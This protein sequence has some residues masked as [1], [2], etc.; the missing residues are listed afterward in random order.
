M[1][2]WHVFLVDPYFLGGIHPPLEE[3]QFLLVFFDILAN[4][5]IFPD[6]M[7]IIH[8]A[9]AP[10]C[11]TSCLL[12]WSDN[13]LY[14][15]GTSRDKRLQVLWENYRKWCESQTPPLGDRAQRKLFTASVLKPDS[16]K[17]VELSQKI[18]NATS[19]RY[20]VFWLQRVAMQF[21]NQSGTDEDMHLDFHSLLSFLN[22]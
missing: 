15:V 3:M 22:L 4:Q 5:G 7:H 18:L 20:M 16:G 2:K 12:D 17:Y 6:S 13:Q 14:I 1:S 9:L 19:A 21:A 11:I 8:L 10:D